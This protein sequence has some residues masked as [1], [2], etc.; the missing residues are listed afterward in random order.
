MREVAVRTRWF[1]LLVLALV[2]V[3]TLP[4]WSLSQGDLICPN[5]EVRDLYLPAKAEALTQPAKI[6]SKNNR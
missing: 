2:I 4:S 1:L 5:L 3:G 6:A